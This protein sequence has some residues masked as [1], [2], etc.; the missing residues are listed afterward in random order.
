MFAK[1]SPL[2]QVSVQ[3]AQQHDISDIH[4]QNELRPCSRTLYA[5]RFYSEGGRGGG[6]N[7]KFKDLGTKSPTGAARDN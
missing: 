1:I 2:V 3:I 4:A 7:P 6:Q 5:E